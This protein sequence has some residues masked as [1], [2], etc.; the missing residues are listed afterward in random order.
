MVS[1]SNICNI[2]KGT[3][4]RGHWGSGKYLRSSHNSIYLKIN[5][6]LNEAVLGDPGYK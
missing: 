3:R 4:D 6:P 1:P 2:I 5:K